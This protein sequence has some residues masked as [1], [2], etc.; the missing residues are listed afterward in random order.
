MEEQISNTESKRI[1]LASKEMALPRILKEI[2][3]S[4]GHEAVDWS[5]G[6]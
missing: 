3:S 1:Y 2:S 6:L 5:S 4:R